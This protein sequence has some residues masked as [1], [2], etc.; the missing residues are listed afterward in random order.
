VLEKDK[1]FCTVLDRIKMKRLTRKKRRDQERRWRRTTHRAVPSPTAI[2]RYLAAFHD[3]EE[4]KKREKGKAFI[5]IANEH[6]KGLMKVNRDFIGSVQRHRPK[7]EATLDMD[8]TIIATQKKD[9]LFSYKGYQAYQPINTYWA[10]QGL[11]LHTQFRD[12]NVPAGYEQLLVLKEA[13][14][15][16][17]KEF[18]GYTSG[19]TLP[20]TSMI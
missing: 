7:T 15:C 12:G 9:A 10:E 8:A 2:F 17:L 18:K 13:L 5:P 3:P 4:E 19:P 16:S 6:L 20:V 11:I 1:G 14:T